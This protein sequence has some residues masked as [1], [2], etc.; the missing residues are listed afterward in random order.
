MYT[1]YKS[2]V[3]DTN[4]DLNNAQG[5]G[6][7]IGLFLDGIII[8]II[9]PQ[10]VYLA[11]SRLLVTHVL[12]IVQF[13]KKLLLRLHQ[14][15]PVVGYFEK[16]LPREK[17]KCHLTAILSNISNLIFFAFCTW[18]FEFGM[19]KFHSEKGSSWHFL[20]MKK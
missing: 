5:Y 4:N 8:Y 15:N 12:Q 19:Q 3:S 13:G 6:H 2:K 18:Y 14:D 16:R 7:S 11:K 1:K 9:C 20:N 10:T 17:Q